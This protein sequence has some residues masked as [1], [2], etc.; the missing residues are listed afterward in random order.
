MAY[1]SQDKKAEIAAELKKVVPADWK[2]TLSVKDHSTIK[3]RITAAPVDLIAANIKNANHGS[4]V[5]SLNQ[6][7]LEQEYTGEL[8]GTFTKIK[9]AL[10]KGNHDN[11]DIQTDYFDVGW[12]V[13][14][15]IGKYGQPFK[16]VAPAPKPQFFLN[17]TFKPQE[18]SA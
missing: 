7:Y 17:I 1:M 16:V 14:I 8:L 12:Y 13:T 5:I 11:S 3:M 4:T 18:V 9:E 15:E 10:Y 6:Y 2:Y